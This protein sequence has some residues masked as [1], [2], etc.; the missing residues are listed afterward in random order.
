VH[1][2]PFAF[3][4]YPLASSA[5]PSH[6]LGHVYRFPP[7]PR[8]LVGPFADF[9]ARETLT[10]SRAA[11]FSH[12][13]RALT[14]DSASTSPRVGRVRV[15]RIWRLQRAMRS[16]GESPDESLIVKQRPG[17]TCGAGVHTR[18]AYESVSRAS[19]RGRNTVWVVFADAE[20]DLRLAR[21]P[22][23][24]RPACAFGARSPAGSYRSSSVT[25]SR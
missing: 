3:A 14:L 12:Q 24:P 20:R 8:D 6:V 23:V 5:Y 7:R 9:R 22:W 4:D 10:L 19:P 15:P 25:K 16:Q 13:L 11:K 2:Q 21:L 1:P 18:S 17:R